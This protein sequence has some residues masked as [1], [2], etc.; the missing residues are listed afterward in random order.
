MLRSPIGLRNMFLIL[1]GFNSSPIGARNLAIRSLLIPRPLGRGNS[2]ALESFSKTNTI[3][4]T[5]LVC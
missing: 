4:R 1:T 3:L 2:L 5:A